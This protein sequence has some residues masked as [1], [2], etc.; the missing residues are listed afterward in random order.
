MTHASCSCLVLTHVAAS[1]VTCPVS[2]TDPLMQTL[3]TDP[4]TLPSGIVMD[5]PVIMRHLLN[6]LTDPFNRQPL[7]EDDLK[8]GQYLVNLYSNG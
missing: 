5:R 8:P 2:V 6:D 4:V 7:T 1:I 3:M